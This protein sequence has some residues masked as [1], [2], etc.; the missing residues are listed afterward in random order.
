MIEDIHIIIRPISTVRPQNKAIN[1]F[2]LS[3]DVFYEW[4][5]TKIRAVWSC[6][7]GSASNRLKRSTEEE[8]AVV[9]GKQSLDLSII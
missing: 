9:V 6:I 7:L 3:V 4:F 8:N 2:P 1:L 5:I